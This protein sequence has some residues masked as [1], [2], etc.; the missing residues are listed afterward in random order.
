MRCI[1]ISSGEH[2]S[3]ENQMPPNRA[4]ARKYKSTIYEEKANLNFTMF[5]HCCVVSEACIS[6]TFFFYFCCVKL[7]CIY[8]ISFLFFSCCLVVVPMFLF[9][10]VCADRGEPNIFYAFSA[11]L[12]TYAWVYISCE[13]W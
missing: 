7:P 12:C 3:F 2:S 10:F 4:I 8:Y 9:Q 11:A 13:Q 1:R 5:T 6:R